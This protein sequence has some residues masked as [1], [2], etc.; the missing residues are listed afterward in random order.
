MDA[1]N[2]AVDWLIV[3]SLDFSVRSPDVELEV[4]GQ[5]REFHIGVQQSLL[6]FSGCGFY[7]SVERASTVSFART[8]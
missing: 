3:G 5:S 7:R 6:V 1:P 2:G 4:W 8:I